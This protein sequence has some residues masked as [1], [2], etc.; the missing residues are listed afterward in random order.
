[1]PPL[2]AIEEKGASTRALA[3]KKALTL[4]NQGFYLVPER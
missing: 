2:K 4:A 3:M 1:M